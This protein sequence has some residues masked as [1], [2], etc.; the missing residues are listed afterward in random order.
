MSDIHYFQRY[1]QKENVVTNNTLLLLN[2]LYLYNPVRFR[3][4]ISELLGNI[5]DFIP[6]IQFSQQIRKKGSVPDGS[7]HQTGFRILIETKLYN[8]YSKKQLFEHLGAF[9]QEEVKILLLLDPEMPDDALWSQL[10]QHLK[11]YNDKNNTNVLVVAVT[12]EKLILHFRE[13]ISDFD[14]EMQ[15]IID[16]YEAYCMEEQLLPTGP[17]K[18]RAVPCGRTLNQNLKYNIYYAP[19]ERGYQKHNYIALYK[20]KAVRAIGKIQNI[21]AADYDYATGKLQLN[22]MQAPVLPE[23]EQAISSIILDTR[24]N[25]TWDI[26]NDHEFFLVEKF[27]LTEFKKK[28]KYPLQGPR[29]FDLREFF[30]DAR[31]LDVS[32]IAKELKRHQW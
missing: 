10:E 14:F 6:G 26:S 20:D 30:L 11:D 7:I 4:F 29:Y 21:V 5:P 24:N 9:E 2:R 18:I 31:I 3:D 19:R 32:E 25:Y 13:V 22:E 12:F 27:H 1:S 17:F 16:D 23:Q 8:Q 15:N 28:T